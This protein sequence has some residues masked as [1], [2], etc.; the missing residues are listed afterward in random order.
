LAEEKQTVA[1]DG[2]ILDTQLYDYLYTNI[3]TYN[4]LPLMLEL[5]A[6]EVATSEMDSLKIH[7]LTYH[8]SGLVGIISGAQKALKHLEDEVK[9]LGV[10]LSEEMDMNDY[11]RY[12]YLKKALEKFL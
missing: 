10:D 8:I 7:A 3:N 2:S 5:A 12:T 11:R 6:Y 1:L 4:E 9:I